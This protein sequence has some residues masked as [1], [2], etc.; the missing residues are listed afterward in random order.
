M[1]LLEG[2]RGEGHGVLV[3]TKNT[4]IWKKKK[5]KGGGEGGGEREARQGLK[6]ET[7]TT[8]KMVKVTSSGVLGS[9]YRVAYQVTGTEVARTSS[10]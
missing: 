10:W 2:K 3:R 7:H 5:K 4:I 1:H 9:L 8:R 6:N